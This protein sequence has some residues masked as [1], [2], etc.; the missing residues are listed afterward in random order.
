MSIRA[1]E[2][3]GARSVPS[4]CWSGQK[5]DAADVLRATR[6]RSADQAESRS[7]VTA[8]GAEIN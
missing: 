4:S 8:V 1:L 7:L 6:E 2:A 5:R 3:H